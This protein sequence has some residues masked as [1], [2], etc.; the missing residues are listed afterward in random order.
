ML[1]PLKLQDES[2]LAGAGAVML[3]HQNYLT[4]F[5]RDVE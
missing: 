4:N 1:A 5:W 3:R 2:T